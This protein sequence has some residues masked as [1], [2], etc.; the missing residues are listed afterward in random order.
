MASRRAP[1][2]ALVALSALLLLLAAAPA[3]CLRSLSA[4][5]DA[6]DSDEASLQSHEADS[7]SQQLDSRGRQLLAP[8]PKQGKKKKPPP[9]KSSPKP[10]ASPSPSPAPKPS[11]SPA[12]KPSP[13]P[14]PK[15]SPS[16]SP[17][18]RP[19]P[20]PKAADQQSNPGQNEEPVPS[21]SPSTD[22]APSPSPADD[23][24]LGGSDG[25]TRFPTVIDDPHT[26]G[27]WELRNVGNVVAV[28]MAHL[29]GTD[30][31][32]FMERP[33]G[34]HPDG[35]NQV[36]GYYDLATNRFTNVP[37]T[38]SIFCAGQTVTQ[39]G[40][41]LVV[42][43]HIAKSGYGDGLKGVRIFSR[44]TL[45]FNRIANMSYPRWYP[46]ST[47]LPNGAVTIMGGSVLPGSGTGK[48][49]LY[50]VWDPRTPGTLQKLPQSPG[51][52]A[53]TNDIYYPNNYILP[54]GA[55]LVFC[56]RYGEVMN[57]YN[58]T[59]YATLPSWSSVAKGLFTEY[60]FTGT[61]AILPLY[62]EK[63][64]KV[65]LVYFGGQFSYSWINTTASK[66]A[67][68]IS[69]DYDPDTGNYTFGDG[70]SVD[71]MPT[72]RVMGDVIIL[73]N[74]KLIVLNG[75]FKGLAGDSA[76]G[77]VAKA[78][79]PN[80]WPV[81]YDPE[82]PQG[83]RFTVLSRTRIPRM[84]HSTVCLTTDGALLVSGCDRCDRYWWTTPG[85]LD[86]SPTSLAEYRIE[87]FRP[88]FWFKD[89]AK[90]QIVQIQRDLY[91]N[92]DQVYQVEYGKTFT[93]QYTIE[94]DNAVATRAVLMAPSA[95]THSTNMNQR[96]VGLEIVEHDTD[97]RIL[98]L[99]APPHINI[100]PPQWYM[101]FIVNGDY[102][103]KSQWVRLPGD[104]P[105]I[106]N[107]IP[108]KP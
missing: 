108:K 77:G 90:P 94:D 4:A 78:N 26:T 96:L 59:V 12:P 71:K 74:G 19:S 65:E 56:N 38:D 69:V 72:P 35:G 23:G 1:A 106:D 57:P 66:M 64:Y 40:H 30:K 107:L 18:P 27:Q 79:E 29:P 11:P 50:E 95:T 34:R 48:N 67:M 99:A 82:A 85:G 60:P 32:F 9:P 70:W 68:R 22:P 62:P 24:D 97:R 42:G 36:A 37:Y 46:T 25:G 98:T 93:V 76:S 15:P 28:H 54:T 81:L 13:S 47:L 6:A 51:L 87:V 41:V 55:M 45:T 88:P 100:A 80:M 52:I 39:D 92:K 3:L 53:R 75:A 8:T 31:Y 17:S 63:N 91:D 49:P 10:R 7:S 20:P 86:K 44:K 84:Y 58:G 61:S 73:P 33:S 101:L 21:P 102:Y 83:S 103:G 104:A 89:S 5:A 2:A 14:S 16:P 43:G 105:T